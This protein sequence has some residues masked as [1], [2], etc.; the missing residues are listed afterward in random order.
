MQIN[1][2]PTPGNKA[3]LDKL[4]DEEV[5]CFEH[6]YSRIQREKGFD[7]APLIGAER[8]AVK[9]YLVFAATERDAHG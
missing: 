9:A 8:A 2:T 3:E 4:L 1:P 7:G 5:K 6:F